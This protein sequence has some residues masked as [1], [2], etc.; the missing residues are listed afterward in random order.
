MRITFYRLVLVLPVLAFASGCENPVARQAA[1]DKA[2][3]QVSRIAEE[4]DK[5][6]DKAG[7]YVRVEE[8]DLKER[9]PWGTPIKVSYAQGG[10]AEVLRVCSAGPD[11]EFHTEDD[12]QA[13]GMSANFK[14]LGEGLKENVEEA[15]AKAAKGAVKG[16]VDGVKESIRDALPG[17]K[18]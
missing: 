5:R 2:E 17:K 8:G 12:V 6:T 14:G 4:L 3:S 15:S 10:V 9:D 18:K 1:I 16:A 13:L 7:V 11:R